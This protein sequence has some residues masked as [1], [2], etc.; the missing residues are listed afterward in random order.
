MDILVPGNTSGAGLVMTFDSGIAIASG[1]Y[2]AITAGAGLTNNTVTTGTET[3]VNV[4]W[5]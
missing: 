2:V 3:T 4:L 5:K 1:L